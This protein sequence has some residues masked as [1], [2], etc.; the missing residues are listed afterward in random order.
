M[1]LLFTFVLTL[2]RPEDGD[3]L[4]PWARRSTIG[5]WVLGTRADPKGIPRIPGNTLF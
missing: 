1:D 3:I 5:A 4:Q 2:Y